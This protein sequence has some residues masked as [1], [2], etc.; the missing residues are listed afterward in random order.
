M[1]LQSPSDEARLQALHPSVQAE[2]QH[3]PSV[4]KPLLHSASQ[5]QDSA[6]P[7]R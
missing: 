5:V 2:A 3:T 4:Q 1:K 6:L 7:F